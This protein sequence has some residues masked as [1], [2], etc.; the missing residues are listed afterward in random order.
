MGSLER[1]D[2]F[3]KRRARIGALSDQELHDYFW[4][5]A[6]KLVAPLIAE[7][8][9]HTTPSIERSVLLRMGFSSVEAK[10]LVERLHERGLLGHGAGKLILELAQAKGISVRA[11]GTELLAGRC[12]EELRR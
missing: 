8:R 10:A 3:T 4:S 5:L 2:D 7:A 12:W 1:A 6:E 11:A 9:T